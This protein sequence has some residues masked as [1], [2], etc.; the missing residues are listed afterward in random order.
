MGTRE[1][2]GNRPQASQVVLGQEFSPWLYAELNP[3]TPKP[4]ES[5]KDIPE[6]ISC[7]AEE[8]GVDKNKA[9][10]IARCESGFSPTAFNSLYGASGIYQHL[11]NLWPARVKIY[12]AP[13]GTS[14]FDPYWNVRISMQMFKENL[15]RLWVCK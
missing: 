1:A 15:W 2:G 11:R 6:L 13:E 9:T 5:W 8:Y 4:C 12:G 10:R 14:P 3:T 7:F